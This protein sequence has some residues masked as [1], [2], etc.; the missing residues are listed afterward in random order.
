MSYFAPRRRVAGPRRPTGR[1]SVT[2][3]DAVQT[4]DASPVWVWISI[5]VIAVLERRAGV[6]GGYFV[7]PYASNVSTQYVSCSTFEMACSLELAIPW[8]WQL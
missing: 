4:G 2:G 7:I 8:N 6:V 1:D 3:L 5:P